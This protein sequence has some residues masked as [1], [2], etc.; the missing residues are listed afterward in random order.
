MKRGPIGVEIGSWS[1]GTRLIRVADVGRIET[2]LK[3]PKLEFA[4]TVG[5]IGSSSVSCRGANV[6]WW[7][8]KKYKSHQTKSGKYIWKV[9]S[10]SGGRLS[11]YPTD[12]MIREAKEIADREGIP[13]IADN[14]VQ[15]RFV[16][17]IL[18]VFDHFP[19]YLL[20]SKT[21]IPRAWFHWSPHDGFKYDIENQGKRTLGQLMFAFEDIIDMPSVIETSIL[22]RTRAYDDTFQFACEGDILGEL[23][24]YDLLDEPNPMLEDVEGF[25]KWAAGRFPVIS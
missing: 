7:G 21:G 15:A 12:K 23:D 10:T 6:Y 17:D 9:D 16:R 1:D 2:I 8:I 24:A 25:M 5:R 3:P 19:T 18:H 14:L 11:K 13:Y 22:F 4:V 20:V